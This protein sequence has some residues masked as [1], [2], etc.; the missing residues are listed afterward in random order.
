M[1]PSSILGVSRFVLPDLWFCLFV[2]ESVWFDGADEVVLNF[3]MDGCSALVWSSAVGG[4]WG[5]VPCALCLVPYALC[6]SA[7][8]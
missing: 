6:F 4:C 8:R 5:F 7:Q 3:C 1:V 2:G